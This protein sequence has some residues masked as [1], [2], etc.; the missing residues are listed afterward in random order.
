MT[1]SAY[2]S[3]SQKM[4]R[5]RLR[6]VGSIIERAIDAVLTIK[7]RVFRTVGNVQPFVVAPNVCQRK[8]RRPLFA[9]VYHQSVIH[10]ER[11]KD[12]LLQKFGVPFASDALDDLPEQDVSGI[13]VFELVAR[14]EAEFLLAAEDLKHLRGGKFVGSRRTLGG[15]KIVR[16]SNEPAPIVLGP[17]NFLVVTA[18]WGRARIGSHSPVV[19]GRAK[20]L[21]DLGAS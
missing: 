19:T 16:G 15:P 21:A 10:P 8:P 2:L 4:D 5:V 17:P 11:I 18:A 20:K 6:V 14:G 1:A 12:G 9:F 7:N 13:A 3:S